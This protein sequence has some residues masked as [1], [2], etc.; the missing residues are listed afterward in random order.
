MAKCKEIKK[1][2]DGRI[3]IYECDIHS[4]IPGQSAHLKYVW[5]RTTT[6]TDGPVSLPAS[7]I[8]TD[9][10][11]WT[12]NNYLIYRLYSQSSELYGH[13]F[14]VCENVQITDSEVKWDD[15]ILDFWVDPN[16]NIYI[17]DQ[18]ELEAFKLD[19]SVSNVQLEII[20]GVKKDI[21][22]NYKE[23]IK[24]LKYI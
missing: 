18:E 24:N 13:R 16:N 22:N 8:H 6:Y 14:D 3:K 9:A 4:I 10:F 23:I 21:L 7:D 2:I 19:N 5:Q 12:N 15:L 17:L 1:H 20:E 11:Y